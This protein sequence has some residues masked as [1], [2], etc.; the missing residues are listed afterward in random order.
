MT[1]FEYYRQN[2]DELTRL[3]SAAT[4]DALRAK[5][6]SVK[7]TFPPDGDWYEW[8]ASEYDG[9]L[10]VEPLFPETPENETAE[11]YNARIVTDKLEEILSLV[12]RVNTPFGQAVT[13]ILTEATESVQ[14]L[15]GG[16]AP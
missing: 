3:L 8:L 2:A 10:P 7:L 5:G 13:D 16:N 9:E 1:N 12:A 6:C 15:A 4:D 14:A 11:Q